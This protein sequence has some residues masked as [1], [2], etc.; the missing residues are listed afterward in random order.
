MRQYLFVFVPTKTLCWCVSQ[1]VV[2]VKE[3][4]RLLYSTLH[5][6][7]GLLLTYWRMKSTPGLVWKC[8]LDSVS[9][10]RI[11]LKAAAQGEVWLRV[12]VQ[13]LGAP[14]V[15]HLAPSK[16]AK[17]AGGNACHCVQQ[18]AQGLTKGC[19]VTDLH[20]HHL[21]L[22]VVSSRCRL[23]SVFAKRELS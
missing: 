16:E 12:K 4:M 14:L 22:R 23:C 6:M 1:S 8:R 15:T 13:R 18:G 21:I 3:N 9:A 19:C 11:S 5:C 10:C 20:S 17:E 7:R 2:S